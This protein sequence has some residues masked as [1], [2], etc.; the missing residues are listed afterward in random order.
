MQEGRHAQRFDGGKFSPVMDE[1][2][3][4]FHH[5]IAERM[6]IEPKAPLDKAS[7]ASG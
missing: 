7:A 2:T 5:W 4:A 1:A 6:Q 3:Y